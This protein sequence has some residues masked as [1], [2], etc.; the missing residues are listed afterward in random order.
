MYGEG[1][2]GKYRPL[3]EHLLRRHQE[4][5]ASWRAS[6]EEIERIIGAALPPS[7]RTQ[8]LFWGNLRQPRR[9]STAWW[10]AG[11]EASGLNMEA[12]TVLF[13]IVR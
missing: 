3:Y 8:P 4:G 11:W 12:E 6:F 7:A 2:T 13:R 1:M 5:Y 10:K 9:A